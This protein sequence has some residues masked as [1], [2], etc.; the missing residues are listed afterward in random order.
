MYKP[1]NNDSEPVWALGFYS[2]SRDIKRILKETEFFKRENL[3]MGEG[4]IHPD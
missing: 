2:V 1:S 3:E 4:G